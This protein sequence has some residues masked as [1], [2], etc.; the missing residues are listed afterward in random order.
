MNAFQAKYGPWAVVTGAS[1][2]IGRSIATELA[3]RGL[4]VVLVA[5]RREVLQ[6]LAVQ[7][8]AQF[9]VE[10]V[11]HEADLSL[12]SATEGLAS[13]T[14]SLDVGLFVASAGFGGSGPLLEADL[15]H[16]LNMVDVNCRALLHASVLFGRRLAARRRGGLVLMS[17]LVAFQGVPRAANYAATK[18]YVQSLAEGL[19][20]E[21]APLGVE[22]IASAPGPVQSGFNQRADMRSAMGA[23]P[24]VVARGTLAA[25]GGPWATARPGMLSKVL[26]WS[27][28][29]LPRA[30]RVRAMSLVMAGMTKHQPTR[31]LTNGRV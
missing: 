9:K 2:G 17:S 14:E 16:E 10:V 28:M 3:E 7:L 1:E 11:V 15:H 21:L 8:R 23:S 6:Q 13:A 31:A 26:E 25:L 22:V 18:A 4:N 20:L 19:R 12:P 5:R 29:F 27:L 30:G 24:E